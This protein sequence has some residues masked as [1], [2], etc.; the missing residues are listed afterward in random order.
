MARE[1]SELIIK[2]VMG[3]ASD[4]III[5]QRAEHEETC[6]YLA[7][8]TEMNNDAAR[9]DLGEQVDAMAVLDVRET[10]KSLDSRKRN[11]LEDVAKPIKTHQITARKLQFAPP[12][13]L[14]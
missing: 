12:R 11:V 9:N 2:D 1:I 3:L 5:E 4:T 7:T 14:K 13:L 8:T 10:P 6:N